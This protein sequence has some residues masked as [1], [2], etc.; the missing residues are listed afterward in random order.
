MDSAEES[1]PSVAAQS[2]GFPDLDVSSPQATPRRSTRSR[3]TAGRRRASG[4]GSKMW[5]AIGGVVLLVIVAVVV[6]SN[7]GGGGGGAE[8]GGE[9]AD[10]GSDGTGGD[11]GGTPT[12]VTPPPAKKAAGGKKPAKAKKTLQVGGVDAEYETITAALAYVREHVDGYSRR[13]RR[14]QVTIN[15]LGGQTYAE[16]IEIDG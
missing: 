14:I 2:S 6:M 5:L 3:K 12:K 1:P 4:K 13:S 10:P 11:A 15:V 16:S 7:I 9:T 8:N